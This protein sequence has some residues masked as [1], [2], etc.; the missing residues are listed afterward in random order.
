MA[1]DIPDGPQ[2]TITVEVVGSEPTPEI[3]VNETPISKLTKV[4][5]TSTD[6]QALIDYTVPALTNFIMYGIEFYASPIAHALFRLTIGGDEKWAD[7]DIPL[8]MNMYFAAARL[9]AATQVLLEVKSDDT[10]SIDVWG[11][12]EGKEVA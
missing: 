10:T 4:T 8:A 2:P 12:L 6:Y 5:T 9:K 3:A 7:K 1:F 11:H